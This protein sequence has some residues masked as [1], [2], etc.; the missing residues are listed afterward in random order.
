MVPLR[1]S[2][3]GAVVPVWCQNM[4]VTM[5]YLMWCCIPVPTRCQLPV[6]SLVILIVPVR[7]HMGFCMPLPSP[8]YNGTNEV[9]SMWYVGASEVPYGMLYTSA[10]MVPWRWYTS[11][12]MVPWR[13][14]TGANKVPWRWYAG[15]HKVPWQWYTGANKVPSRWYTSAN[16]VPSRW[17]TGA[18]PVPS[19]WH[20]GASQVPMGCY[21]L[22]PPR[23]RVSWGTL[24]PWRGK[25]DGVY[26]CHFWWRP[27]LKPN[28]R[29]KECHRI[30][31]KPLVVF[32][33]P[34]P[35]GMLLGCGWHWTFLTG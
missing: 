12:N 2:N 11:A 31:T 23:Y 8:W 17:Y 28:G 9:L 7:C 21:M 27:L 10:N 18:N 19:L 6:P 15:A 16:K 35:N 26:L 5:R 25:W 33:C 34:A 32:W 22:V 4:M 1:W 3:G 13:W 29:T 14:Y 30:F 20:N 24:V